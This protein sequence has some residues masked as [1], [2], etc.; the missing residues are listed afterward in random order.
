MVNDPDVAAA[1]TAATQ[2][3][4]QDEPSS[5]LRDQTPEAV[6]L[7]AIWDLLAAALGTDGARWPR[8]VTLVD[9]LRAQ[10]AEQATS[11][12]ITA[13]TPWALPAP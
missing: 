2:D 11:D 4:D 5:S 7:H 10:A 8:P 12:V 1:I 6:A 3:Q 9:L 13:M